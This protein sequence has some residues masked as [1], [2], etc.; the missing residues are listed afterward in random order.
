WGR[1]LDTTGGTWCPGELL[2]AACC[3]PYPQDDRYRCCCD[4]THLLRPPFVHRA[5]VSWPVRTRW[6][7]L[8]HPTPRKRY[9]RFPAVTRGRWRTLRTA[10]RHGQRVPFL[11]LQRQ[12]PL[13]LP[14]AL[15]AG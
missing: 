11:R 12:L 8:S 14:P 1:K 13:R 3:R 6:A 10:R 2:G 4:K 9:R 7:T 5:C 15:R